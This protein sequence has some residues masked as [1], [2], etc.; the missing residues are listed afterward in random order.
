M[1]RGGGGS[2]LGYKL[3]GF[4]VI[5]CLEID[6]RMMQSYLLN[7]PVKYAFLEAI[8]TF[9]LRDDLPSEL[10]D[11]DILDGSPPCSAFTNAGKKSKVWGVK[12]AFR[13]GQIKQILDTLFFDFID[14]AKRLQPKIVIA[15]NVKGLLQ[16]PARKYVDRI[17]R[18][19]DAAGYNVRHY[20]LN[21]ATMGVPQRR[22]RVFFIAVRKDILFPEL[23]MKFDE[24]EIPFKKIMNFDGGH[25]NETLLKLWPTLKPGDHPRE[26]YFS[27]IKIDPDRAIPTIMGGRVKAPVLMHTYL[28]RYINNPEVVAASSFPIDYNFDGS[29]C[30]YIC[31]MS[32]P[33]VMAA[34][35][36]DRIYKILQLNKNMLF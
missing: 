20:L 13:E 5:G 4:D 23:D 15:E 9:K 18:E 28:K 8:Q 1:F 31:G 16:K 34:H 6:K 35:V 24:I 33:P 32:V 3:A 25:A 22:E 27:Y 11:L 19:L 10:F 29:N 30:G 26:K 14:L 36:A 17:Y 12:K 2:S 21:A 7:N